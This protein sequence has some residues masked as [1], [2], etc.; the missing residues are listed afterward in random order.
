MLDVDA[1]FLMSNL[2]ISLAADEANYLSTW[3]GR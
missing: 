1:F 2:L 3:F